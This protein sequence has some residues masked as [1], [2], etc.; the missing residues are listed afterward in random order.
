M[1]KRTVE[2]GKPKGKSRRPVWVYI[3]GGFGVLLVFSVIAQGLNI[4]PTTAERQATE[5][6]DRVDALAL[7][8]T[9]TAT[10]LA[11][12]TP[13]ATFAARSTATLSPEPTATSEPTLTTVATITET[14]VPFPSVTALAQAALPV[15][16]EGMI[17]PYTETQTFYAGG[18]GAN[19][20]PEPN[21]SGQ[22]IFQVA[23]GAAIPI[24]GSV[25]GQA[26][27]GA[28]TLWY[29]TIYQ[30]RTVYVYSAVVSANPPSSIP[31]VQPP[32]Q[33]AN[34]QPVSQVPGNCATAV[35]MGLSDRQAGQYL[36]ADGDGVAC[37][38]D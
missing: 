32:V 34:P 25:N 14:R 15:G 22:V 21:T 6:A 38:G 11:T 9:A 18:G 10:P 24:T 4:I 36:D 28:N 27:E 2:V 3:A 12:T 37:Y 17:T 5:T 13:V 35:A 8:P 19:L 30:G 7:I 23:V 29:S 33:P 20:R 16:F 31:V 1:A 26:V